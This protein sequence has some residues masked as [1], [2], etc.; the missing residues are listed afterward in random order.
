VR[1][2]KMH[3]LC[4]DYVYINCFD[5]HVNNPSVLAQVMSDRHQGIGSDGVIMHILF[6]LI[7]RLILQCEHGNEVVE[8]QWL[9]AQVPVHVE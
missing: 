1:F 8:L 7:H 2:T 9:V 5:E 3:G 6:R 4:N